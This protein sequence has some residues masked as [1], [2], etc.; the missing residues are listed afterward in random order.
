MVKYSVGIP[1]YEGEDNMKILDKEIKQVMNQLSGTYKI[2]YVN[3]GSSDNSLKELK[4]L[5]KVKIIDINKNY[6]QATDNKSKKMQE[7]YI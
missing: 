5:S 2:I 7:I 4:K 6:G 3:D 1:I